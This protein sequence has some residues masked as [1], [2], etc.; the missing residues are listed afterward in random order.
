MDI[1][2]G[3]RRS[4]AL[5]VAIVRRVPASRVYVWVAGAGKRWANSLTPGPRSTVALDG[6][7]PQVALLQAVL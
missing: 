4:D 1:P 7:R 5:D 6:V 3:G 2:D